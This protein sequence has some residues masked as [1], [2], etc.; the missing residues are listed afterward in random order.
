MPTLTFKTL[1]NKS[2]TIEIPNFEISV[3]DLKEQLSKHD[4]D[5]NL[6][7][8]IFKGKILDNEKQVK[9]YEGI[10]DGSSLVI[11]QTKKPI[12]AKPQESK[13]EEVK[14]EETS[15][16]D[17]SPSEPIS[18]PIQT[19]NP[20]SQLFQSFGGNQPTAPIGPSIG[21]SMMQ[22]MA[23]SMQDPQIRQIYQQNP[24]MFLNM[25]NSPSFMNLLNSGVSSAP[26]AGDPNAIY[27]KFTELEMKD[28]NELIGLGFNKNEVIEIYMACNKDKESSAN[29]LFENQANG[30]YNQ[31]YDDET[32]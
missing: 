6:T 14:K 19:T 32:D 21:P 11:M 10:V 28:I 5:P 22:I 4:Y 17:S 13:K 27:L 18:A 2:T 26:M 24:N 23:S 7:K 30:Q 9:S 3:K 16:S 1:S 8:I 15:S 25:I 29:I 20:F 31:D 12:E